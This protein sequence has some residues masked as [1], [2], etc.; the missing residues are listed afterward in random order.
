MITS[1]PLGSNWLK[2]FAS[3]SRVAGAAAGALA[4][5]LVA[6]C[7]VT[8]RAE[9]VEG[10]S[11]V[12]RRKRTSELRFTDKLHMLQIDVSRGEKVI[13]PVENCTGE[14]HPQITQIHILG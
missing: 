14:G 2:I 11:K 8:I 3:G 5:G 7:W 9:S 1:R 10:D 6:R 12:K 13:L 4:V